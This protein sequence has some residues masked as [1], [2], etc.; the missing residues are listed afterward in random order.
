MMTH[1]Y[2]SEFNDETLDIQY[3]KIAV[4]AQDTIAQGLDAIFTICRWM[5]NRSSASEYSDFIECIKAVFSNNP[6]E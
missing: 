6:L 5:R 1:L 4:T 2:S 3:I